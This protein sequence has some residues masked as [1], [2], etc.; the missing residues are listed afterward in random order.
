MTLLS[1][2]PQYKIELR[3]RNHNSIPRGTIIDTIVSCVPSGWVVNL[4]DAEVFILVEVFK[5]KGVPTK[6][7]VCKSV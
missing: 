1:H 7:I 3:V 2:A 5:V 6:V 4:D